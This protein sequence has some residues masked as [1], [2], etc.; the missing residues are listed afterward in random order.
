MIETTVLAL[1]VLAMLTFAAG[2]LRLKAE[3]DGLLRSD[4]R[5]GIEAR[6]S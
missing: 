3:T 5:S 4:A 2:V 6:R 1:F